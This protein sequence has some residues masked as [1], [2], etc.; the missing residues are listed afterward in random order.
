MRLLV[1]DEPD[2]VENNVQYRALGHSF[3]R[4][5]KE[6]DLADLHSQ[7]HDE[8]VDLI[9]HILKVLNDPDLDDA[10]CLDEIVLLYQ[11]RLGVASARHEKR[12]LKRLQGRE[13]DSPEPAPGTE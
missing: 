9:E 7:V 13:P 8:A 1:P 3:Y 12:I 5:L 11:R 10:R 6:F 4:C 2:T